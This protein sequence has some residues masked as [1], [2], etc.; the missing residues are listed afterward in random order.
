MPG[1][2]VK[3]NDQYTQAWKLNPAHHPLGKLV[4]GY[5]SQKYKQAV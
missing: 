3:I 4:K 2:R 1:R 5:V